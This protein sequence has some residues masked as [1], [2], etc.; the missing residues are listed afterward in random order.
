MSDMSPEGTLK[1]T[2]PS[3]V[4]EELF[5]VHLQ[6]ERG[7]DANEGADQHRKSDRRTVGEELWEIHRKRSRGRKDDGTDEAPGDDGHSSDHSANDES[8]TKDHSGDF[9]DKND[10]ANQKCR[11]NLRS[12]DA[13]KK[14]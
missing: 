7:D 5:L 6:R 10:C 13:G 2:K 12:K 4:G 8:K 1:N 3:T 9:G 14:I 11:Y